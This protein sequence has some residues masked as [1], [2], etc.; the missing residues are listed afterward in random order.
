M[1]VNNPAIN[2]AIKN[3]PP[4]KLLIKTLNNPSETKN[5]KLFIL[6][7]AAKPDIKIINTKKKISLLPAKTFI[8]QYCK[9]KGS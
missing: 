4:I 7:L 6:N 3:I 2:T 5:T 1:N 9:F 8:N